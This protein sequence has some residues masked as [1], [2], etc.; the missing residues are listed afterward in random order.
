MHRGSG[1]WSSLKNKDNL[2]DGWEK[3]IPPSG[4]NEANS[5]LQDT[6][7]KEGYPWGPDLADSMGGTG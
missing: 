7:G 1:H 5:K 4:E 2:K 6:P 3:L